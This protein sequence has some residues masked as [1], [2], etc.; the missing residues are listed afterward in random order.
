MDATPTEIFGEEQIDDAVA[1]LISSASTS[2]VIAAPRLHG[3][4][5]RRPLLR[6]L[7]VPLVTGDARNELRILI[8]EEREFMQHNGVLVELARRVPDRIEVRC[9]PPDLSL[10]EELI[11]IGDNAYTVHQPDLEKAE[12]MCHR[13]DNAI[14]ISLQER[15]KVWWDRSGPVSE[16]F[17]TGL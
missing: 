17:I 1:S 6:E 3:F 11:V 7:L 8:S 12:A 16:L 9:T 10:V 2:V 14:A 5:F 4:I 15:I 13:D